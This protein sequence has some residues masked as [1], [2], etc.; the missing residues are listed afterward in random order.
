MPLLTPSG[1]K[2]TRPRILFSLGSIL[3][4]ALEPAGRQFGA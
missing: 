1:V 4:E 2:H 3:P